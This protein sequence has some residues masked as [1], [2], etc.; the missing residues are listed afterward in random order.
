MEYICRRVPQFSC[1]I[2]MTQVSLNPLD[3]KALRLHVPKNFKIVTCNFNGRGTGVL[4]LARY[5]LMFYEVITG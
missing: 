1:V 3:L 4:I 2:V 5:V